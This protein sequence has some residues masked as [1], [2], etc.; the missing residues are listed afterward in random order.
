MSRG[1]STATSVSRLLD[2]ADAARAAGRGDAAARLY[3]EAIDR[4]RTDGELAP[5]TRAVLGAAALQVF[6]TDPGRLA[7]QLHD[8]LARTTDDADRA[9][10][11]AALARCWAYAGQPTR[12]APFADE[13]LRHAEQTGD[14]ELVAD[15][16]DAT[17]AAHWGPDDLELRTRLGA[18]LD[19]VSAHVL[20]PGARLQ[21]H[22]WSLQIACEN[23]DVP[24]I[25][26][27]L[28]ALERL[29]EES[30]RARFFA[31][32]R[33]FM[34]DLLRG[35]H[36]SLPALLAKAEEVAGAADLADG[37]VIVT[38]MRG[39]AALQTGD[40][41]TAAATATEAE[42]WA[43]S[44]GVTEVAAEAAWLWTG[45]GRLDDARRVLGSFGGPALDRLPRNVH[46]LLT[47][48]CVL[49]AAL[50]TDEAEVAGAAARLLAPY[51]GRAV[52]NAGA[53]TFHGVTDDTLA[54]AAAL[55][56]DN[57]AADRLR[58]RALAT[59]IRLGATWWY[60]RLSAW[61]PAT[62]T[63]NSG[64]WLFHPQPGGIWLVG[65]A[66]GRPMR[67]LRGHAYLHELLRRPGVAVRAIDLVSGGGP[68]VLQP[69]A[70]AAIDR[71]AAAAYRRRLAAID[72]ELAEAED[73][74]D[75]GRTEA[76]HVER[77]ALL[78]EL[79]ADLGLG[80]RPRAAGSSTERARVAVTK[81]IG[82]ALDRISQVDPALGD[83]L[84]GAV[85]T[86]T[87]CCY[88]PPPGHGVIWDLG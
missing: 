11:A 41:A 21:S 66:P 48:Q 60:E 53:V 14:A 57:A 18:R 71:Q 67:Q 26:R 22:L 2:R 37:W 24:V 78:G 69:T 10:V 88:Q 1:T 58:A 15:C 5:W 8:V 81:A 44:E 83:H 35:N 61:Q 76:L 54:R 64:R 45:A 36:E 39:Y 73:W 59:Y 13:A 28:R 29:G 52:F 46:W 40:R 17:L 79:S 55:A 87:E 4:C 51:A 77:E 27:Q 19:E 56:G 33:R 84:R 31:L 65:P 72:A 85:R 7:A 42:A 9:R 6:G 25:H 32:S 75:T 20:D 3:D 86:G 62:A 16:L 80:S 50:A 38:S 49:E 12:A 43:L 68:T 30:P 47:L 23:L 74:A 63:G 34:Y 70:G 82:S